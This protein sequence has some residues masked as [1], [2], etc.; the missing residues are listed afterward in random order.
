MYLSVVVL[1]F[2]VCKSFRFVAMAFAI[3]V[4]LQL[5][6]KCTLHRS[7]LPHKPSLFLC[8]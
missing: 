2:V 7:F 4:D 1:I 8:L 5:D 3:I 6:L